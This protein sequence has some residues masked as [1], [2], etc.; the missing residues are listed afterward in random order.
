[1][2]N[3]YFYTFYFSIIYLFIY[4]YFFV[5]G[6]GPSSAHMGWAGP[7]WLG[8]VTGLDQWPGWVAGVRYA[9]LPNEL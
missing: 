2:Q 4:F 7:R 3:F 9:R 1:M 8:W 6:A 5:L